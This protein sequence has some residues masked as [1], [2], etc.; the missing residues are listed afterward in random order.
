MPLSHLTR[1]DILRLFG[2]MSGGWRLTDRPFS[3]TPPTL[4]AGFGVLSV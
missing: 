4:A 3:I 1:S 2:T